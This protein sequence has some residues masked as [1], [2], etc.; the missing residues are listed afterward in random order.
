MR[1]RASGF[2]FDAVRAVAIEDAVAKVGG[3]RAVQA[4][5][6]SAS[7]VIWYFPDDCDTAAVLSAI[8]E[9]RRTPADL[10]PARAPYS[11]SVGETGVVARIAGGILRVLGLSSDADTAG[12]RVGVVV[13]S[14]RRR[15]MGRRSQIPRVSSASGCGGCRWPYR[16]GWCRWPR[17][18]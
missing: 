16:W 12:A 10:V 2:D 7:V 9:A 5:P 17:R 8:A 6:R 13:M 11:A 15:V 14:R 18:C 4:Y 3:V 1:V